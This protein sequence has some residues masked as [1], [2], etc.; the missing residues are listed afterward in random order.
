MDEE[1]KKVEDKAIEEI[2]P[3]ADPFL[4]S[5]EQLDEIVKTGYSEEPEEKEKAPEEIL[6]KPPVSEDNSELKTPAATQV[7][8]TQEMLD[9]MGLNEDAIKLINSK[10]LVGKP[11]SEFVNQ[12]VN[13]QKLVGKKAEEIHREIFPQDIIT[14]K[15]PTIFPKDHKDEEIAKIKDNII[16]SKIDNSKE[17]L[18]LSESFTLPP[19]LD[20]KSPEYKEWLRDA[21]Y[22]YPA[23]VDI[24]KEIVKHETDGINTAYKRLVDLRENYKEENDKIIDV[25]ISKINEYFHKADLDLKE[26]GVEFNDSVLEGLIFVEKNGKKE[27]DPQMFEW[28]NGEIPIM[29]Q[30]ALAQKFMSTKG[31]EV[32]SKVRTISLEK[33]RKEGALITNKPVNKGLG[34]TNLSGEIKIENAGSRDPYLMST[35]ELDKEIAYQFNKE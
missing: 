33:G 29:K 20:V 28:V 27:L 3:E 22:E 13:A 9:G 7:V 26:L 2:T 12:Y 8:L 5:P 17:K 30:G 19:T 15:A 23:D 10:G 24:F 6:D 25:E 21:Q 32:L 1:L 31:A 18:G 34:A 11:M 16:L 14:E 35:S 4:M